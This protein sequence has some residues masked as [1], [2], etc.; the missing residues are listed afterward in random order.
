MS[1]RVGLHYRYLADPEM[2]S[3]PLDWDD[4]WALVDTDDAGALAAEARKYLVTGASLTASHHES[5]L[6]SA[7]AA[8]L[9]QLPERATIRAR[10]SF[11]A[12]VAKEHSRY[13]T[14]EG[15]RQA[16]AAWAEYLYEML[17]ALA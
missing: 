2:F 10:E 14:S 8:L 13:G 1:V 15:Q 4:P 9:A 17:G 5:G 12:L 7:Q 6:R 11:A 3:K 16:A